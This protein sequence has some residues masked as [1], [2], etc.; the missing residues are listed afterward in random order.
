MKK[1][2][3]IALVMMLCISALS[4]A[5]FAAETFTVTVEMDSASAPYAWAWGDYGN[6]FSSWPGVPMTKDGDVWKIDVP[7]GTTGFIVNNGGSSKTKDISIP[8]TGDV[9]I[10]VSADFKTVKVEGQPDPEP[11]EGYYVTGSTSWLGNWAECNTAGKMTEV[12]GIYV[13]EFTGVA[14]GSYELKVNDGSWTNS[15]GNGGENYKF[16]V[17]ADDTTV[18]VRFNPADNS[19]VVVLNGEEPTP[20]PVAY[21]VAGSAGLCGVEWDCAAEVNKMTEGEDGVWSIVYTGI[22]AGH[23]ELKVTDGTWANSWGLGEDNFWIDVTGDEATVTVYFDPVEETVYTTVECMP[24]FDITPDAD[25]YYVAGSAGLCGSEWA[26]DD[27]ANKMTEGE[28]GLWSITYTGVA[29]GDYEFKITDGTWDNTWGILNTDVAVGG[30]D[31]TVTITFDPSDGTI[32]VDCAWIDPEPEYDAYY[33]AGSAGLCGSEWACDDEA[34]KMT[35]GEDGLWSITYTG[36][37]AGDYEFKITDGTWDNTWGILNTDVAVGGDDATVTITFDPS[38]GTIIVDCAWIDPEPEYDTY[39]VTG[40]TEWLG[41]WNE[42]NED[43]KMTLENGVWVKT[44]E[45]VPAGSVELKV[46]VGNWSQ[47]WGYNGVNFAFDVNEGDT[48]IVTFDPATEIVSVSINGDPYNPGTG[49]MS[50]AGVGLVL[51]VAAA[52]VVALVGKKKSF[53]V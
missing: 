4:M 37:A 40:S 34:N 50:L 36:V 38:D 7:M 53:N 46:N 22:V 12:D 15:W 25:A 29:A 17:E 9:T 13:K 16:T 49:D 39:Y 19:V 26:C 32:I 31:A 45:N 2:I 20:G 51:L 48:V 42:C 18:T 33:V 43:G 28:D 44:F 21:Y 5:A 11:I 3:A 10:Q 35:E 41:N 27:E 30:D 6:A 24:G 14:A 1:L 52:G 8:G 23:Y 47:A